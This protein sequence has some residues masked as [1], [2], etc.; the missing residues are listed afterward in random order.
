[1]FWWAA[2]RELCEMSTFLI[3]V[4][5]VFIY[6]RKDF[7]QVT[8]SGK[9]FWILDMNDKTWLSMENKFSVWLMAVFPSER[10]CIPASNLTMITFK[11]LCK[12]HL[13]HAFSL[14]LKSYWCSHRGCTEVWVQYWKSRILVG[15]FKLC[16]FMKYITEV[17]IDWN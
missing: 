7:L 11:S 3:L 10:I 9:E 17:D 8:W 1:M 16:I 4:S 14:M 2:S 6:K 15:F 5:N 13:N 12:R